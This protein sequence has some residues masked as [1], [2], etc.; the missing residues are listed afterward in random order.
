MWWFG[1]LPEIYY[2]EPG[3]PAARAGFEIGD[4]LTRLD[5]VSLLTEE[6]GRRFG[7]MR[8]GQHVQWTLRRGGTEKTISV[9]T[10]PRPG[11]TP[12]PLEHMR[13]QLSELSLLGEHKDY[14]ELKRLNI[15]FEK[16]KR[17][18]AAFERIA[19]RPE[20]RGRRLRYAGTV[21]GSQVEVRGLNNVVVDE[22]GDEI[23][24][25]TRDAMI[26]IRP[27]AKTKGPARARP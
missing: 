15:D 8:P 3:S 19:P 23:V 10:E 24:I 26:R 1:T 21:G 12:V 16:L 13:E 5:G 14:E 7:A 9:V 4:V 25:T 2:V 27:A 20:E 6:G 11:E 22:D 18:L 17:Q